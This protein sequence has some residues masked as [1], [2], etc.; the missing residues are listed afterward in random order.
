[1]WTENLAYGN[2]CVWE[3][4]WKRS[5]LGG[6]ENLYTDKADLIFFSGSGEYDRFRLSTEQD[7]M[8][9]TPYDCNMAWGD[10]DADWMV[11]SV[12]G[13][14]NDSH[15]SEWAGCMN[16]LRLILGFTG[17]MYHYGDLGSRFGW[18]V[19][20]NYNM[21]QAWFK[22]ADATQPQGIEA[23]VLAEDNSYFADKWSNDNSST[24]VD[25]ADYQWT[26][27]VGSEPPRY[28]DASA[29]NG[30][31]PVF[32]TQA[33]SLD[34]ANAQ[35]STLGAAFGVSTTVSG[36]LRI[37]QAAGDLWMSPDGQLEMDS[38]AGLYNF[39][40]LASLWV[41]PTTTVS[42]QG[43]IQVTPESAQEIADQF[44][45]TNGLKPGDASFYEVTP[46]TLGALMP[47]QG[48]SA[49]TVVQETT[50]GWQVI[51]SRLITY[52]APALGA[53]AAASEPITFSVIGPG[54][55]LK[56]YVE[57]TIPAG[58]SSA[59][60]MSEAVNGGMGGWR[61]LEPPAP[62]AVQ[63][64][65]PVLDYTKIVTLFNELENTVVLGHDPVP[66]TSREILTHTL[67]YYEMPIGESQG[68]L[69]PVYALQVRSNLTS[70]SVVTEF[71]YIPANQ[72]YMAPL[73]KID[74]SGVPAT[75]ATGQQVV[76]HA[77][78]ASQPLNAL[79]YDSGLDFVL[80]SGDPAS[81]LYQWYVGSVDAS[82]IGIGRVLTHT[83]GI[84]SVVIPELRARLSRTFSCESPICCMTRRPTKALRPTRSM[85]CL[86]S[87]CP[88]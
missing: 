85:S 56:V 16:G 55:K 51:C 24:T 35:W 4:D 58:L 79:G 59:A 43:M 2:S 22:A 64:T 82:P 84:P 18:Y 88:W 15:L 31:M 78:D 81:Y 48:N 41:P 8:A 69:I 63:A 77:V 30:A 80:G 54:A 61:A 1:M 73:A 5:Y 47:G 76:L 68:E 6:D 28:V 14:L 20:F 38:A 12:G 23:N 72:T 87:T 75:V 25:T 45:S 39:T 32:R 52:T 34:A 50:T 65:V 29:L 46:D 19:R 10:A 74:V 67:S 9:V 57:P 7:D 49:A 60:A 83:A 33:L 86:R 70:G 71:A 42:T 13:V 26:H 62:L 27:T 44:L 21:T 17:G 37:A 66:Y 40:E 36:T 53:Q 3:T 11:L